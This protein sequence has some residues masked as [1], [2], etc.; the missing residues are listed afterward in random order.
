MS[1]GNAAQKGQG[2]SNPND[3]DNLMTTRMMRVRGQDLRVAAR[4]GRT[5]RPPLLLFNGIGA[6][7][8]LAEPFMRGLGDTGSVIFDAPGVGGSP[9]PTLPYRPSTVAKWGVEVMRQLGHERF[10]VAGVSWGGAMAQQIAHQFPKNVRRLV[11]AATA[12]GVLMVPGKPA[13]LWKLASPRRYADPDYMQSIA[14]EIYGGA[15]RQDPALAG[16]HAKNMRS[17]SKGGYLLQLLA[18]SGWTSALWL[19]SLKQRTLI[20][21]GRDDPIVPEINGRILAYLIPHAQ[22]QIMRCGHLFIVTM[23]GETAQAIRDFLI[24]P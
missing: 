14:P 3:Q 1:D 9:M 23:P 21:M 18:I 8:E 15:F 7:L 17:A 13:V 22:L 6:N 19:R 5:D 12:P 16:A 2:A 4:T 20:M 10:D 11:L 24:E